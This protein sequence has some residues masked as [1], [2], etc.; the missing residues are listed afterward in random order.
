MRHNTRWL[1][2]SALVVVAIA[3]CSS[4][5]SEGQAPLDIRET[6]AQA[7]QDR[8]T[9]ADEEPEDADASHG[10]AQEPPVSMAQAADAFCEADCARDQMCNDD[11][12]AT[13]CDEA[14]CQ[15][16]ASNWALEYLSYLADCIEDIGCDKDDI[17]YEQGVLDLYPSFMTDP[18]IAECGRMADV[19]GF[20]KDLC[21][22]MAA[23]NEDARSEADDCIATTCDSDVEA[24]LRLAGSFTP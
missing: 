5:D 24:C 14:S 9:G 4:S 7:E 11:E 12:Q 20:S 6:D 3:G 10:D 1:L 17:C 16:D 18:T 15:A 13:E 21:A 23:L 19:C 22:T 8:D 2:S